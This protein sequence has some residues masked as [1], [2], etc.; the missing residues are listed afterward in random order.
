MTTQITTLTKEEIRNR[1]RNGGNSFTKEELLA[2]RE[3]IKLE[4]AD[5]KKWLSGMNE[6]EQLDI[7][8][9]AIRNGFQLVDTKRRNLKNCEKATLTFKRTDEATSLD[10]EEAK[11][12]AKLEK[13]AARKAELNAVAA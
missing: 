13:I 3:E 11:L 12:L 8:R 10:A 5:K 9:S 4:R 7:V 2:H 6:Q 1:V